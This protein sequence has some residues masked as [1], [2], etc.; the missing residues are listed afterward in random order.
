[1]TDLKFL[2]IWLGKFHRTALEAQEATQKKKGKFCYPV[3]LEV[4]VSRFFDRA[5]Q[6]SE[7]PVIGSR[8]IEDR[9]QKGYSSGDSHLNCN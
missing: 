2:L 7:W 8:I 5:I 1:M 9:P 4:L 6:D 3:I